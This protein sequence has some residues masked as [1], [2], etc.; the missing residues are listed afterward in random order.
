M[1]MVSSDI[2][3]FLCI[4]LAGWMIWHRLSETNRLWDAIDKAAWRSNQDRQASSDKQAKRDRAIDAEL[5][6]LNERI[7]ALD[8]R[9]AGVEA[10][11]VTQPSATEFRTFDGVPRV[12]HDED[13]GD[14]DTRVGLGRPGPPEREPVNGY[15]RGAE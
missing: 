9:V 13:D 14:A 15:A 7:V 6:D 12:A 1:T 2:I 4:C 8:K 5:K 10:T 11:A 3:T